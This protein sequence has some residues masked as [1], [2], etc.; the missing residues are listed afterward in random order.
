MDKSCNVCGRSFPETRDNF[1]QFKNE[2]GGRVTIGFRNTCRECM[3]AR[4]SA[5]ARANPEQR[6]ERMARRVNREAATLGSYDQGDISVIRE[7]LDD[8]C[9][10]CGDPLAGG[11]EVD[12]LTPVARGGTSFRHNISLSCLPCNRAKLSKTL[13]EFLVWRI[14]RNLVVRDVQPDYENPDEATTAIL[15]RT[16]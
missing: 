3:R 12:H 7:I 13:D 6:R 11:G 15:R 5:H 8:K 10:Y 4:S 16:F 14:E 9:R 1:G 2:S